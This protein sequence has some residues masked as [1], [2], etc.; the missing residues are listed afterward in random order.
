M[1]RCLNKTLVLRM[2]LRNCI[3]KVLNDLFQFI[4]NF[5][6]IKVDE[7]I[8]TFTADF[9]RLWT[10]PP[11]N[12]ST[13]LPKTSYVSHTSTT[14]TH[15][16]SKISQL[17]QMECSKK[18]KKASLFTCWCPLWDGDSQKSYPESSIRRTWRTR[19]GR[20]LPTKLSSLAPRISCSTRT[21]RTWK[22]KG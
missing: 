9:K 18:Q 10:S 4:L 13:S 2:W 3:T 1:C 20:P 15:L 12:R 8:L 17:S 6:K 7:L 5:K 22:E 19:C 16:Y 11:T 21:R 14:S